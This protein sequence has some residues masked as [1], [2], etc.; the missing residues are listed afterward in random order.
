MVATT[1]SDAAA[2]ANWTTEK[3]QLVVDTLLEQ[4]AKGKRAESGFK[5]E[6]WRVATAALQKEFLVDYS[7]QQDKSRV[8][9]VCAHM[10]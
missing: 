7:S 1:N 5:Q 9:I 3:D 2:R 6:A 8:A 4:V 10:V